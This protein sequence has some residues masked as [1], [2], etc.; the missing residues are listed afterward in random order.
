MFKFKVT[1]HYIILHTLN[2]SSKWHIK[3]WLAFKSKRY[4]IKFK[5]VHGKWAKHQ[6]AKLFKSYFKKITPLLKESLSSRDSFLDKIPISKGY[7]EHYIPVPFNK[8]E[9]LDER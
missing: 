3:I 5:K 2:N 1:R 6:L 9:G 4:I 7:K 8:N